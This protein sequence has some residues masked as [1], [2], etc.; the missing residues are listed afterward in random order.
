MKFI[1]RLWDVLVDYS[2]ELYNFRQR[3]YKT[4]L[5]DRYI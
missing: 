3:Y 1:N 4:S 2:E 5:F